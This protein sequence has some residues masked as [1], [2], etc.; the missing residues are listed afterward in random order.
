MSYNKRTYQNTSETITYEDMNRIEQGIYDTDAEIALQKNTTVPG[1]LARQ[2]ADMKSVDV[3]GS[4]QQQINVLTSAGFGKDLVILGNGVDILSLNKNVRAVCESTINHPPG[5]DGGFCFIENI[6]LDQNWE[7]I[8]YTNLDTGIRYRNFRNRGRWEGWEFCNGQKIDISP[9]LV[10]G[11]TAT[12]IDYTQLICRQ[13]NIIT[14]DC[15]LI[16]ATQANASGQV[17]SNLPITPTK[18]TI[19]KGY[20]NINTAVH[21]VFDPT[22][23]IYFDGSVPNHSW[24][25]ITDTVVI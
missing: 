22:G 5:L 20:T 1:T 16:N 17:T 10:N 11:W 14:I 25:K 19:L 3:E 21:F 6:Y 12:G 24:L 9:F 15:L 23:R 2:I 8:Y 7:E 13:G 18:N 4:L